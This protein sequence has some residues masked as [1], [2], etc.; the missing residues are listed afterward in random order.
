MVQPGSD[1]AEVG[2]EALLLRLRSDAPVAVGRDR[3]RAA[4]ELV[5]QGADVIVCDDGLQHLRLARD[6]ELAV[7]DAK[8]ELRAFRQQ[9]RNDE[10]YYHIAPGLGRM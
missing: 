9:M 5:R 4:Q 3:V 10:L 8:T 2:D 6:Y 1:A 7:I